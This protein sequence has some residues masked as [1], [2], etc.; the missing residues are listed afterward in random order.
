MCRVCGAAEAV[1]RGLC[2]PHYRRARKDGTLDE[3]GL[4][5]RT[6]QVLAAERRA[7]RPKGT[8]RQNSRGLVEQWDGARW[9]DLR[10]AVMAARLG[11]PLLP[12]EMVRSVNGDPTDLS[13]GNLTL[14]T[15]MGVRATDASEL[16]AYAVA[17]HRAAAIDAVYAPASADERVADVLRV[18]VDRIAPTRRE[19]AVMLHV[20]AS[21]LSAMLHRRRRVPGEVLVRALDAA[22]T[23]IERLLLR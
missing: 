15:R 2:R 23:P 12:E 16:V 9:V 8:T 6:S 7:A 18:V 3:V 1:V 5:P 10:R 11:R 22:G 20:S 14:T 17:H 13:Q 19:A 4:P 21:G